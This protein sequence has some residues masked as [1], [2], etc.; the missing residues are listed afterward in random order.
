MPA[1]SLPK[2]HLIGRP[3]RWKTRPTR[4]AHRHASRSRSL[5]R[6][7]ARDDLLGEARTVFV[8]DESRRCHT[9][10]PDILSFTLRVAVTHAGRAR[11]AVDT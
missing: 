9:H 1:A 4:R 8:E 2:R 11:D 6:S 7:A 3:D 10:T 5:R